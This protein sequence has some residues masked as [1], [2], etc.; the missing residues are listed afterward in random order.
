MN[1]SNEFQP[2]RDW[3]FERG[4]YAKGDI[5][6]QL[7]KLVEEQGELAK[8]ILKMD[9]KEF[10]DAIGDCVVVLTNLAHLGGVDIEHCINSSY[11]EISQRKGSMQNGTFVKEK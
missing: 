10:I 9:E 6:T 4:L 7:V 8:A 1:L 11:L 5:K 2:I 3:A